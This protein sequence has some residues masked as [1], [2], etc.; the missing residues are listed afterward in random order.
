MLLLAI[1]LYACKSD[2]LAY[3]QAYAQNTSLSYTTFINNFHQ[4][5]YVEQAKIQ[6]SKIDNIQ[7][8]ISTFLGNEQRNFYGD[9]LPDKLDT[10]WSFHLGEGMSPAYGYNKIWKGAGWTGQPSLINENGR[11]YLIQP[12]FDYGLHKLDAATGKQV[13]VYKYDDILKGSPS[14]C[15]NLNSD[16]L[17]NRYLVISGSRKGWNKDHS[18][19][20]CWSLR[21]VSYITGKEM[22]RYSSIATPCYSRDV[23]GS[24]LIIKDTGYLALENGLFTVFDPDYTKGNKVDSFI[25]PKIFKQLQYFN[26]A[27][28]AAHGDD[29]VSESSPTYFNNHIYT[30]SGTGWI[31]GYNIEKGKNDWEFYIGCDI[32]GTMPLTSDSC[33]LVPVEREYIPGKG[34]VMK[35]DPRKSPDNAVV[36]FMPTDTTH[37]IHWE[38]G[39]IGSITVNDKTKRANDP[40]ICTFIDCKGDLYVVDYKNVRNDTLVESPDLKSK[41]KMPIVLAKIH[42]LPTISTPIIAQNRILVA[43]DGALYLFQFEYKNG[44]FDIKEIDKRT[45]MTFDATPICWHGR[46]YLA[47]YTGYM[48]CFGRK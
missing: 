47:D 13:W 32:D 44:K 46:I 48:W 14:I 42:L 23:D 5:K 4:S 26:E 1:S 10:I 41:Y 8:I 30:A 33:L 34:G 3:Q 27:D 38:G 7:V 6:R 21:C 16:N 28:I 22:W 37:W 24:A 36:W 19:T 40:S 15:T 35:I 18:S 25:S 29:L 31:Y 43:C 12:A 39:I 45:N 11:L 2:K 17:E 20:Y 9:S